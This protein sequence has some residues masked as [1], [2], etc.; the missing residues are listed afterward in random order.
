MNVCARRFRYYKLNTTYQFNNAVA[1]R[2]G[3]SGSARLNNFE[4]SVIFKQNF[5]DG[6]VFIAPYFNYQRNY[7]SGFDGGLGF[8]VD[9]F[10]YNCTFL[11]P[12][13]VIGIKLIA[14]D[15]LSFHF[16]MKVSQNFVSRYEYYKVSSTGSGKDSG[17]DK[18]GEETFKYNLP[19]FFSFEP[20][21]CFFKQEKEHFGYWHQPHE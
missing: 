13:L 10:T 3:W 14:I 4:G 7:Q 19:A 9:G 16:M 15:D 11:S 2:G 5:K 6:F 18:F 12:G 21:L 17:Y 20:S 1:V 8:G